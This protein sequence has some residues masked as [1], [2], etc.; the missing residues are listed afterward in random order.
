[1]EP[2]RSRLMTRLSLNGLCQ[3]ISL[4]MIQNSKASNN[5]LLYFVHCSSSFNMIQP[6][7][8]PSAISDYFFLMDDRVLIPVPTLKPNCLLISLNDISLLD[9]GRMPSLLISF[10]GVGSRPRQSDLTTECFTTLVLHWPLFLSVECC[11]HPI[12]F[13]AHRNK[14]CP[15]SISFMLIQMEDKMF[16][17]DGSDIT[18]KRMR[19][20]CSIVPIPRID[21]RT[22]FFARNNAM[23]SPMVRTLGSLSR[24]RPLFSP[25]YDSKKHADQLHTEVYILP[26]WPHSC[27]RWLG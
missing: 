8:L 17:M 2:S 26:C 14:S 15:S 7:S 24:G 10:V 20:H 19:H 11:V 4:F 18:C 5:S 6:S 16:W 21:L 3:T 27:C 9:D 22:F 1:M 23:C 25:E 12:N 13:L